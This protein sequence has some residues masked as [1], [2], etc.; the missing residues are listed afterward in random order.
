MS[1][2]ESSDIISYFGLVEL[3]PPYD[4]KSCVCSDVGAYRLQGKHFVRGVMLL[5]KPCIV[6]QQRVSLLGLLK[7]R[8]LISLCSFDVHEGLVQ[9]GILV[10]V[11]FVILCIVSLRP[12]RAIGYELFF[13]I[14]FLT[15]L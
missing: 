14:H 10:A 2:F 8:N 9:A 5:A 1:F 7:A 15:V 3:P 13:Y 6:D 11:A 12:I 4:R